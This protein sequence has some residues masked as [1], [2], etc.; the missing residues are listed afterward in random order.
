VTLKVNVPPALAGRVSALIAS[1]LAPV[2]KTPADFVRDAVVHRLWDM[3]EDG[4][5]GPE[6]RDA[7]RHHAG[8]EMI[9]KWETAVSRND[10]FVARAKGV[11]R[12]TKEREPGLLGERVEMMRLNAEE[13]PEPWRAE[14][15]AVC[16]EYQPGSTAR[17]ELRVVDGEVG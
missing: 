15:M 13:L 5:G 1:Q 16:E 14:M 9:E 4:I 8:M 7:L 17:P 6:M 2:Y 10:E 3:V 12:L 11:M